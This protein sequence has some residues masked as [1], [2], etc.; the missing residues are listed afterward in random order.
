MGQARATGIDFRVSS[1]QVSAKRGARSEAEPS[2]V[3]SGRL[4][5]RSP[6]SVESRVPAPKPPRGQAAD[7]GRRSGIP[8]GVVRMA[9]EP[10]ILPRVVVV[11][12]DRLNREIFD[13]QSVEA[14]RSPN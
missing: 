6:R 13:R 1:L 2:G 3:K 4:P 5:L 11:D 14:I 12:D 10:R 8:E 9:P 7:S